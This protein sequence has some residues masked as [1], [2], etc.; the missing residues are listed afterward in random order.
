MAAPPRFLFRTISVVAAVPALLDAGEWSGGA[1]PPL[2]C[3][4]LSAQHTRLPTALVPTTACAPGETPRTLDS[5]RCSSISPPPSQSSSAAGNPRRYG[6]APP[7]LLTYQSQ[8]QSPARSPAIIPLLARAVGRAASLS[9]PS[10]PTLNDTL[11]RRP[12]DSSA[13][14]PYRSSNTDPPAAG[15]LFLPAH[16]AGQPSPV[17]VIL[18]MPCEVWQPQEWQTI[19]DFPVR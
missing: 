11:S 2:L 13:C 15:G 7:L 10:V 18:R 19:G 5:P 3:P 16:R 12:H 6:H 4:P 17:F 14:L 8:T 1:P 9:D